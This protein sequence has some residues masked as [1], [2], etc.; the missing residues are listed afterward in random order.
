MTIMDT[1]KLFVEEELGDDHSQS[2]EY[3]IYEAQDNKKWVNAILMIF[4]LFDFNLCRY[5]FNLDKHHRISPNIKSHLM[6]S[7][8]T[9]CQIS[10]IVIK[11]RPMP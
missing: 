3:Q 2:D 5:I 10:S 9:K 6:T 4:V 7:I 1:K 8:V 11:R